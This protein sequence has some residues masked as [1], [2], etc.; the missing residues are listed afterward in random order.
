MKNQSLQH[1]GS[2]ERSKKKVGMSMFNILGRLADLISLVLEPTSP[3]SND[4][5]EKIRGGE[6][7][8]KISHTKNASK[9]SA[10]AASLYKK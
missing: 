5:F 2:K 9:K 8:T 1:R 3:P 6:V 4:C 10:P 7:E